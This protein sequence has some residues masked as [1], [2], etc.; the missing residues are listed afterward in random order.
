MSCR[1]FFAGKRGWGVDYGSKRKYVKKLV[2]EDI[3]FVTIDGG[4]GGYARAK[5][6]LERTRTGWVIKKV[7]R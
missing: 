4:K 2:A 3:T 1:V 5:G 7:T 6:T